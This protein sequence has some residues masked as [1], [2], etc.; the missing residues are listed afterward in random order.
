MLAK[1][2]VVSVFSILEYLSVRDL[3]AYGYCSHQQELKEKVK[4]TWNNLEGV[5]LRGLADRHC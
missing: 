3:V 2:C 4:T 1:Q 5:R